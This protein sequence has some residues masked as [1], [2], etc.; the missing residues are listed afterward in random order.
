MSLVLYS[1]LQRQHLNNNQVERASDGRHHG[2]T[3]LPQHLQL[4]HSLV[5]G[6]PDHGVDALP[7]DAVQVEGPG[8]LLPDISELLVVEIIGREEP[9]SKP[10]IIGT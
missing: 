10:L 1:Y 2:I 8:H 4:R 3:K 6:S 5:V 7:N 9:W